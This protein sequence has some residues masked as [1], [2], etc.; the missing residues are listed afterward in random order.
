MLIVDDASAVQIIVAHMLRGMN[1]DVD[2]AETGIQACELAERSRTEGSPYDL[3]LMDIQMPVMSGY[4]ATRRLRQQGWR[5]PIVAFTAHA[6]IGDREKCLNAGCDDCLTKPISGTE[7]REL[8]ARHLGPA[9]APSSCPF[10]RQ[11]PPLGQRTSC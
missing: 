8:L 4:E 7:L 2:R 1:V 9:A 10:G 6:M 5:S 3:I 11:E